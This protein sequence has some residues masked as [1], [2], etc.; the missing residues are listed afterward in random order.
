MAEVKKKLPP[1][2]SES[3]RIARH[4]ARRVASWVRGNK[5]TEDRRKAQDKREKANRDELAATAYAT[6]RTPA[7]TRVVIRDGRLVTRSLSPS[8]ALRRLRRLA[9][10]DVQA[11]AAAHQAKAA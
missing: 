1:R 2:A 10:P 4:H 6:G 8:K 11:R 5:R 9:D 7:T 3:D